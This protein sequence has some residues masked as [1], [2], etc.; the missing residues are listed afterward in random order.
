MLIMNGHTYDLICFQRSIP[1]LCQTNTILCVCESSCLVIRQS[2]RPGEQQHQ[3]AVPGL[4]VALW[5]QTDEVGQS[6]TAHTETQTHIVVIIYITGEQAKAYLEPMYQQQWLHTYPTRVS[7][8]V[9]NTTRW[10]VSG[11]TML[12]TD[13]TKYTANFMYHVI[14]NSSPGTETR[15][16]CLQHCLQQI[17]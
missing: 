8:L 15:S 5:S 6:L 10:F 12:P 3:Q 4:P 14:R 17:I 16:S 2:Q 1:A 9:T 13:S 7:C 11:W